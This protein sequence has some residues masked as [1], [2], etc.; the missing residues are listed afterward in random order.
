MRLADC[1][2]KVSVTL[3]G[4]ACSVTTSKRTAA[5]NHC[6]PASLSCSFACSLL[7][8][9]SKRL[10]PQPRPHHSRASLATFHDVPSRPL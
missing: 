1:W 9:A 3:E 5:A 10:A 6:P 8:T 7:L 2:R 4:V